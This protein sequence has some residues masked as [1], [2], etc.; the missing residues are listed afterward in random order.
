MP[1]TQSRDESLKNIGELKME[2]RGIYP[3][4]E[5]RIREKGIDINILLKQGYEDEEQEE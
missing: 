3:D 4:Y 2:M 1:R 5:K